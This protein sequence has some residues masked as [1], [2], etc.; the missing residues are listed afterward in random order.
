VGCLRKWKNKVH[1]SAG[2]MQVN[3][4]GMMSTKREKGKGVKNDV[5]GRGRKKEEEE[6]EEEV[7]EEDTKRAAE[8]RRRVR[9]GRRE[10]KRIGKEG[11]KDTR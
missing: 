7:E 6:E 2:G 11:K 8:R 10:E 5:D 9:R 1:P 3:E 4:K